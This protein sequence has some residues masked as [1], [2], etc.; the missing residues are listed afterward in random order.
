M[1]NQTEFGIAAAEQNQRNQKQVFFDKKYLPNQCRIPWN[2]M[3]INQQGEVYI[4]RSPSWIPKFV[5]NILHADVFDV[6]NSPMAMS[7]RNEIKQGRYFYCNNKICHFFTWKARPQMVVQPVDPQDTVALPVTDFDESLTV[8]HIPQNLIFDFDY[9]CNFACPSC[10]TTVVNNNKHTVIRPINN[11][12]VERIKHEIIDRIDLPTEIRWCGGELFI[13]EPYLD[14]FSYIG[15]KNNANI[16]HCIQTNGSYLKK[17][18]D[19]LESLLPTV[20]ELQ[21]SFDA[22]TAETYHKI[23]VNGVWDNLIENTVWVSELIKEKNYPTMLTANFV[24]QLDN[25]KE[26]PEFVKL[27]NEL[28]ITNYRFEKMWNWGTWNQQEFDHKNIYNSQH[29]QHAELV[30]VFKST[31]QYMRQ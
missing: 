2:T 24:V 15:R 5:G 12:I 26:I 29:P 19:V 6:L 1:T 30:E 11:N 21:I 17:K 8:N 13:S 18:S 27:C 14:L 25:Y 4:C 3:G 31:K 7:I 16:K 22:A 9:T 28:K 23:R 10:R 20:K